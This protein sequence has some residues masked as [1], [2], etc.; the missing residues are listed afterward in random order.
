MKKVFR[1]LGIVGLVAVA[2]GLGVGLYTGVFKTPYVL[3]NLSLGGALAI[4]SA[5]I[6]FA[7][8]RTGLTGRATKAGAN[9]LIYAA[10]VLAILVLVNFISARNHKRFDLTENKQFSLSESTTNILKGLDKDIKVWAFYL[11]GK[12][13]PIEDLLDSYRY[14]NSKRF[15]WE[16]VDPDKRP[17]LTEK[18]GVRA[19]G[20]LVVERGTERKTLTDVNPQTLEENLT[21]AILNLTA[22]GKKTVCAVEGHGER[23]ISDTQSEQGLAA[24]KKA[25]E[26]E[27]FEV[28]PLLLASVET[29]PSDCRV[30][31]IAGPQRP[32]MAGETAA[33]DKFLQGGGA[34]YVMLE[35]NYGG[36]LL[37][38]LKKW[39]AEAGND[40]IVDRVLRLF[41][42]ETLG[43]QPIINTYDA[44]HPITRGFNKQ[45]VLTQARSVRRAEPPSG[46]TSTEIVKTGPNSWAESKVAE[47]F[48]TGQVSLDANDKPG[49]VSVA[50]AVGPTGTE[51]EGKAKIVV[52]GDA[53]LASNRFI[54]AFFNNDLFLNAVNWL[55]NQEKQISIRPKG[56]RASFVRLTDEQMATIFNLAVLILPQL[57]LTVGIVVAWSRR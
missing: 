12:A 21:N 39:G 32:F 56:P 27:N 55:T 10:A 24:A 4:A 30:L 50:V 5:A 2:F 48:Q 40:I 25:L 28:R 3:I 52:F 18:Y 41:E 1:I 46:Y 34:L 35:P 20:T 37:D 31:L 23:D 19:N 15:T 7:D 54:T 13:G 51:R 47:L 33:V 14:V 36:P 45:T 22:G 6:N 16:I 26:G 9:A 42:G 53:D 38:L 49:P 57:L 11:G 43:L 17:E 29:V 44:D 8:L